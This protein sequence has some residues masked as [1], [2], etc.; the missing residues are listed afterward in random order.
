M[1]RFGICTR[2]SKSRRKIIVP[3][4][5]KKKLII[6]DRIYVD[7]MKGREKETIVHYD[8]LGH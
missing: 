3:S 8:D 7:R 2:K 6:I 5:Y 1:I 4:K